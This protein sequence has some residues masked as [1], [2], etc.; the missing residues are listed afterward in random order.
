MII[1]PNQLKP[2]FRKPQSSKATATEATAPNE[3]VSTKKFWKPTAKWAG[4]LILPK[5]NERKDGG[6]FFEVRQA[7]R[8][9][10]DLKGKKLWLNFEK[11]DWVDRV[12]T[13]IDFS[14]RTLK[15]KEKGHV[16]PDRLN[17]WDDVS[18]MESLAGAR[19]DDKMLV[20]LKDVKLSGDSI[21]VN[22][23]PVQVSGT[24]KALV[25]FEKKIDAHNWVVRHW[26]PESKD[27]TGPEEVINTEGRDDL[28]PMKDRRLNRKGWYVYGDE[29]TDGKMKV[30]ALEP[31]E[32]FQVTTHQV[33]K[34]QNESIK[35]LEQESWRVEEQKK[36]Q[37]TKTLLD[38]RDGAEVNTEN[39][40]T[41]ME[42]AFEVGD[43]L[44]LLHLFG[45]AVGAP[46]MMGVFAGH[47][48]F[49]FAEI[50]KDEFTG[51]PRID[52][53]YKQVYAHNRGGV[54]SGAQSWHAY[55]GDTTRGY[56]YDRPI[57]DTLVEIPELF[58]DSQGVNPG[59]IL[60]ERLTEM[61]ARYRSG[62]GDASSKVTAA[63]NCSQDS[64]QALYAAMSD[65][66]TAMAEGTMS[67]S[68]KKV[69]EDITSH[70]TPFFGM[71][72]AA[73]RRT[74]RNEKP[75]SN[76]LRWLPALKS[77]KTVLPRRN[78]EALV[79]LAIDNKRPA[80]VLKTS[81]LGADN[82][83]TIPSEPFAGFFR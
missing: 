2:S 15:S 50:V 72:P 47:F 51:E 37:L 32:M 63:Q 71:A 81:T 21:L 52:A 41:K 7:P 10:S 26:N 16:H 59:E 58:D 38:P 77:P 27:F 11:A 23:E 8:N 31:R 70:I 24:Q 5:E 45:G 44:L 60:E 76:S 42:K 62:H 33:M 19:N 69:C 73:W 9:F 78:T 12:T 53:E 64:T 20:T 35:F 80:L 14:K 66:K 82:P 39:I 40:N 49:G 28:A 74:A 1:S 34:G 3:E 56:L 55:M 36:G 75:K 46:A 67:E 17:G 25:S 57:Q 13:D 4:R 54:V 48:S 30:T 65:W 6:V 79:E 61:M 22:K 29:S 68:L 83:E 43:K 18:P